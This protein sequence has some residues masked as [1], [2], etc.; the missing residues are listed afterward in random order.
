MGNIHALEIA[1]RSPHA[2]L[3][4]PLDHPLERRAAL[5]SLCD[6]FMQ[7]M[8]GQMHRGSV[9]PSSIM[10]INR[11]NQ[12]TLIHF[13]PLSDAHNPSNHAH[14]INLASIK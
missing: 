4:P 13:P 1:H 8:R 9:L 6:G 11:S 2:H 14:Q 3:V 5:C 12:Y 10:H 7:P